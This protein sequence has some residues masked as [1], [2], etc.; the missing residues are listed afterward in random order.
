MIYSKK[1]KYKNIKNTN[2][3]YIDEHYIV[4]TPQTNSAN[5]ASTDQIY[6]E[7]EPAFICEKDKIS[8]SIDWR[9]PDGGANGNL[10]FIMLFLINGDDG[11]WW[12]LGN[13]TISDPSTPMKWWNTA[14]FTLNT[15]AGKIDI[16]FT[17]ID[18]EEWQTQSLDSAP[19][20][21]L[22]NCIAGF[23]S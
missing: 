21:L 20:R 12:Q 17:T 16:D 7:S 6:I 4:I 19:L 10:Y 18:E 8:A 14:G 13:E 11:S 9:V 1:I 22:E 15:G 3:L 5:L 23:I 2:R